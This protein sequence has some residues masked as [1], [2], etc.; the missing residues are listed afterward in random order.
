[1]SLALLLYDAFVASH[2]CAV[3]Q[4]RAINGTHKS[5]TQ[6]AMPLKLKMGTKE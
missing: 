1:M 6:Q 3:Q 5:A 2:T 4:C